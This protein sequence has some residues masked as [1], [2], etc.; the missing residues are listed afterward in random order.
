MNFFPKR[1]KKK[2]GMHG[3]KEEGNKKQKRGYENETKHQ[4]AVGGIKYIAQ[5]E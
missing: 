4:D 1:N 5:P 2:S 3:K